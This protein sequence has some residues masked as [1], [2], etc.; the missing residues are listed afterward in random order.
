MADYYLPEYPC[1]SDMWDELAEETR[2]VMV[3][4]MGNGADKLFERLAEFNINVSDVFASDG[5]VR[6]HSFR[7]FRVKSFSE[8]KESYPEFEKYLG[9]CYFK[10]CYHATEPKCAVL[11]AV[12]SGEIDGERHARYVE[13]LEE[14]KIRW[15]ERYD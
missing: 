4:G 2:P 14:M 11:D 10:P 12:K 6:G 9:D 8:I 3:Y 1:I 5:F 7:G 15:R 13:L